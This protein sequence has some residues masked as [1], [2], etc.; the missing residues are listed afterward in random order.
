MDKY[1][2][3]LTVRRDGSSNFGTEKYGTFPAVSVGWRVSNESFLKDAAWLEDLKLRFGWGITGN[4]TVPAGNASDRFGGGTASTFYDING[5]NGLTTGY[6]LARRGNQSTKW[7]ENISTNVGLDASLFDGKINFVVDVYKR[8]VDGLLFNPDLPGVA[9]TAAPAFINIAQIDNNGIDLGLDYKNRTSSDFS[10]SIGL[11]LSRYKTEVVKIDGSTEVV[12]P[13]G[14]DSR[15]GIVNFYQVGLP[16]SSFYGYTA[17]G[18]FRSQAEVDAHAEQD[19]KAVGRIRFKD[20]NADGKINDDDKGSIGNPHPD[21]YGGLNLGFNF[22]Q[23]DL[24]VF[25]FA[26]YGNEIFRYNKLFDTFGFFN[27]NVRKDVLERSFHPTKNPD[28][29]LP[30][31][32]V[33]DTYSYQPSS[34]FVEDA[35]YLRAKN[36]QIGYNFKPETLGKVFSSLRVY[37]QAQNLFTITGYEGLDP[38]PSNFGVQGSNPN[39]L[40]SAIRSD[41]WTG[42]DFGNYP[43][44]KIFMLGINA[45]F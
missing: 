2:V 43:A 36:I 24:T 6:S 19:G 35:S 38:A 32:N 30:M 20:L 39:D 27:S 13:T 33:N 21:F 28:G 4:Q 23:F 41:I 45:G 18:L 26:S 1:L 12:F 11:T 9:G 3:S 10:Y 16:I 40:N 34:F 22:K 42:F 37:L 44:S 25:L 15:I 7:E 17:D 8:T 14:F 5:S 29:D 31:L